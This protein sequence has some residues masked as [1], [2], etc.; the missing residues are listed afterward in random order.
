MKTA[1]SSKLFKNLPWSSEEEYHELSLKH[2][3]FGQSLKEFLIAKE[4]EER[5]PMPRRRK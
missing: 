1:D 3:K 5:I 2:Q 4:K